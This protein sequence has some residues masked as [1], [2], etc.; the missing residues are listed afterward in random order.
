MIEGNC[1][2]EVKDTLHSDSVWSSEDR[3]DD[4]TT[5]LL[6]EQTRDLK[7]RLEHK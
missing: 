1:A 3:A 5:K 6:L 7:Q 2:D 4:L